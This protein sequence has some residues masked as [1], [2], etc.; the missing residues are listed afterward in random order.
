MAWKING[1][2]ISETSKVNG[3]TWVTGKKF[4]NIQLNICYYYD[5]TNNNPPFP[6]S[7]PL[8]FT[9]T[10]CFGNAQ[11]INIMA[12]TPPQQI[13]ALVGT[14]SVPGGGSSNQGSRCSS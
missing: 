3:I 14:V 7:P 5:L 10:D 1:V 13:C 2:E 8:N 4:N 12:G 6:P 9:Y 11:N